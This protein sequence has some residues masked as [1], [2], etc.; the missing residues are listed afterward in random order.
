M[1]KSYLVAV[2]ASV[3]AAMALA[4][5]AGA[6]SHASG[7]AA[8]SVAMVTSGTGAG[9]VL[10]AGEAEY[11]GKVINLAQSWGG[12]TSCIV[13]TMGSA[14]CFDTQAEAKAAANA[15]SAQESAA[16]TGSSALAR[17]AHRSTPAV[18]SAKLKA[19]TRT[20]H[21]NGPCNGDGSQ[22]V[23]LYQNSNYGGGSLGLQ[24][25]DTWLNLADYSFQNTTSSYINATACEL[26]F[27][28][29]YDG[30]G[31]WMYPSPWQYQSYIGNAWND[32][33]TM[34]YIAY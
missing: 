26:Y 24:D 2:G 22:F 33:L 11:D 18:A 4:M 10:P 30:T 5:P 12:A 28:Q 15:I 27:I 8:K 23:W 17:G 16:Q 14:Q 13:P 9:T 7:G 19:R 32:K 20:A 31:P 34:V 25:S 1:K 29:T 6:T 3:A 21:G